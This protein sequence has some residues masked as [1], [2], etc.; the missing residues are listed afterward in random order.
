[1]HNLIFEDHADFIQ[2]QISK[3]RANW[4]LSTLDFDDVSQILLFHIW[5]KWSLYIPE[6]G[7]LEN[8]VNTTITNRLK[9]L[10]RDNLMKFSRPCIQKC[11][12]NLGGTS[13]GFT[14]SKLQD[15]ECPRYAEWQKKKEAQFNIK[16]SLPYDNHIQEI[17]NKP[18]DSLDIKAAKDVIDEKIKDKLNRRERKIYKMLYIDHLTAQEACTTL[19]NEESKLYEPES[20]A[21]L[22]EFQKKII[23]LSKQIILD[24]N[25]A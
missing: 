17:S 23:R 19:K 18:A 1:M 10:L 9:N 7:P 11:V 12:F 8:W 14:T 2:L 4:R 6:K 5:E 3:R 13:C 24:E 16:A 22:L 25:L 21:K 20:Y 15:R